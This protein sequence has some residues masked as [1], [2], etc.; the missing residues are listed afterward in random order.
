M[1]G[2]CMAASTGSASDSQMSGS[3]DPVVRDDFVPIELPEEKFL[4]LILVPLD[5]RGFPPH[6]PGHV[7]TVLAHRAHRVDPIVRVERAMEGLMRIPASS[8]VLI[9]VADVA[10]PVPV[11]EGAPPALKKMKK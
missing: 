9:P 1:K 4:P 7:Y 5:P 11:P 8:R 2:F 3:L 6:A 10:A